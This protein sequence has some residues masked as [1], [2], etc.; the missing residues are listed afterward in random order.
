MFLCVV[1]WVLCVCVYYCISMMI[2][3]LKAKILMAMA[4]VL[5][6]AESICFSSIDFCY[7]YKPLNMNPTRIAL[8]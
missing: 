6:E 5:L 8:F 1:V 3:L 2:D 4:I 7:S